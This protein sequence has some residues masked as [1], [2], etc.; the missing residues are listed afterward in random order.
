MAK[1]SV[2]APGPVPICRALICKTTV[3]LSN[4]SL[5]MEMSREG[6]EKQ[7]YGVQMA[8]DLTTSKRQL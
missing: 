2:C 4:A 5:A 1:L 8:T 3:I 7:A 6:D